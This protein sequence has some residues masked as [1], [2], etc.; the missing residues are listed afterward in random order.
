MCDEI[1]QV[2]WRR[3]LEELKSILFF[4]LLY[5]LYV[6][7]VEITLQSMRSCILSWCIDLTIWSGLEDLGAVTTAPARAF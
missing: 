2:K 7:I 5:V 3:K 1:A 4:Y 6:K